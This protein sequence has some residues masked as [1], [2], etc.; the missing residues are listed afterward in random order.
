MMDVG[1]PQR[2]LEFR[3]QLEIAVDVL[4]RGTRGEEIARVG[5]PVGADRAQFRQ[6]QQ[7]GITAISCGPICRRPSSVWKARRPDCGTISSSPSAS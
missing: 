3:D 7:R 6:P 2:A 4:E 1:L 5:Q